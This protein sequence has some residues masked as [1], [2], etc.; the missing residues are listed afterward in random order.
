[1]S[2]KY[3]YETPGRYARG[4]H[5]LAF[6][7]ELKPG[8]VKS[9]TY[10]EQEIVLFRGES[11][12]AVAVDAYCPHLGANLGGN[13]TEV[14]GDSI[15]CPFHG[16]QFDKH[17]DCIAIPYSD[18]I[19]ERA[20]GSLK[21]WPI[22]EKNGFI[23]AWHDHEGGE[24]DYELPDIPEWGP[25][26]WGDWTFRRSTIKSQGCEIIENIV[27]EGHF[28]SVHGGRPE[29]FENY[30]D[31]HTVTQYSRIRQS[32]DDPQVRMIIPPGL[33]FDL[34][35]A[36]ENFR[37]TEDQVDPGDNW[38]TYHGPSI[39]YFYTEN[40]NAPFPFKSWWLNYYTP[41]DSET[42]DLASSVI[43]APYGD[44]ELPQEFIDMYP[45]T[46][47]AAFQQDVV[48]WETKIY[49]SDPILCAG[50]G[51]INKLRKWYEQFYLPKAS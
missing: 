8:E 1:M 32:L 36:R 42:L 7:Q 45:E 6:S 14:V 3:A 43:V 4:W 25:E 10:F 22:R 20:R 19:P 30:F 12:E 17:G 38:A 5:V 15:R 48:I 47:H 49:R 35:E 21:T 23:V 11:G 39:M 26:N 18:S 34:D 9:M 40:P 41:I 46:A 37:T 44:N 51:A 27:D 13:G 24:P 31:D 2:T 33:N 28:Y 16:W 29:V 50:D